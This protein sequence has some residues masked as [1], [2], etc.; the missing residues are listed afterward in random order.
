MQEISISL[1]PDFAALEL[2]YLDWGDPA[3]LRTVIKE[4]AVRQGTRVL[5]D[6]V[7]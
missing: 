4:S 6:V 2:G 3:A 1:G 7:D 5:V